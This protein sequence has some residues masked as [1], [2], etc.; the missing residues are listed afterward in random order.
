MNIKTE[1]QTATI[2]QFPARG[3]ASGVKLAGTR[4]AK[5]ALPTVEFGSGWYHEAAVDEASAKR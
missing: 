5:T 2:I 4:Y 3:R 1:C